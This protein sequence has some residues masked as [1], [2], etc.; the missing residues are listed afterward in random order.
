M[1]KGHVEFD[2]PRDI[3]NVESVDLLKGGYRIDQLVL[4]K[5]RT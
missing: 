3:S 4:G 1:V 5:F 2:S